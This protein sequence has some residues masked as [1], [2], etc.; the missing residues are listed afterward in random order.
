MVAASASLRFD[1]VTS[2]GMENVVNEIRYRVSVAAVL[3][4]VVVRVASGVAQTT[5]WVSYLPDHT[6][7]GSGEFVAMTPD[8]RY[9]AF[10]SGHEFVPQDRNRVAD[11]YVRDRWTGSIILASVSSAGELGNGSS[12]EG[13]AI[14]A[15]GRFVAF[16]SFAS[17]LVEG[18]NNGISD[19]FVHDCLTGVTQRVNVGPQ[20]QE[21][22]VVV[23]MNALSANGRF[24]AFSTDADNLVPDDT[25][26]RR[27]VFVRDLWTQTTERVSV[28]SDGTQADERSLRCSISAD[29]RLVAFTSAFDFDPTDA[30]GNTDI[31]VHDRLTR[32]TRLVTRSGSVRTKDGF[33]DRPAI[34]PDGR[35]VAY[36]SSS[37]YLV[38][39][40]QELFIGEHMYVTNLETGQTKQLDVRA[41]GRSS[42]GLGNYWDD[43]SQPSLSYDGRFIAFSGSMSDLVEGDTNGAPD[44]FVHDQ[45]T[46]RTLRVSL[47]WHNEEARENLE[48]W[49]AGH[50]YPSI[51][52]DGRYVAFTS[53]AYHMVPEDPEIPYALACVRDQGPCWADR[54]GDANCDGLVDSFDVDP[55]VLA[56]SDREAWEASHGCDYVCVNDVNADGSVDAFDVDAFVAC[57]T[58]GGC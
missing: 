7:F 25:N 57:L 27:D 44:V 30:G 48:D 51:S 42:Q 34:S 21:A 26:G 52:G 40:S 22:K 43:E 50:Q 39:H 4:G 14:S 56:L 6:Y 49:P 19:L 46:G 53:N 29:G 24:I 38:A 12:F 47:T 36:R 10:H 54:R 20:G 17:N 31:Y 13:A 8:A 18:D 55:F 33:S 37:T 15:D 23:F 16:Q 35:F 5:E 9:V 3:F 1:P 32:E 58:G 11:V 28:A 2:A 45:R 41:D